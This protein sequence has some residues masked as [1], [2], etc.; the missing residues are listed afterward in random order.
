MSNRE[1]LEH[2]TA[3]EKRVEEICA[4]LGLEKLNMSISLTPPRNIQVFFTITEDAVST[5]EEKETKQVNAQFDDM[6]A[7]FGGDEETE[8]EVVEKVELPDE[9]KDWLN[10]NE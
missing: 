6:M 5:I 7:G 2:L 4:E 9:L 8:P 10:R 1:D 3:L